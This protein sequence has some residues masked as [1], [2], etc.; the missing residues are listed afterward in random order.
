MGDIG[1]LIV[2]ATQAGC[3]Y[4]LVALAYLL[5]IRPTGVINFSLGEWCMLAAFGAVAVTTQLLVP[6]FAVP[7]ALGFVIVLV[8][9]GVFGALVEVLTVRPLIE[10]GAPVMSPILALLGV[11]V[12]AREAGTIAGGPDPLPLDPPFGF[13]RIEVGPFAGLPQEFFIIATTA[14]VFV[15]AWL[16]FERTVWGKRFEAVAI[17]RRAAALMGINLRLVGLLAFVGAGLVT[18]VVGVLVAGSSG[19]FYLMGLPL[20][21]QGF[22]ALVIGGIG[23]VEG[24]LLGGLILGVTEAFAARYLPIPSGLIQ[25]VPLVLLIVFLLVRPTGLLKAKEARL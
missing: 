16:F 15:A 10:R 2:S 13:M 21:I 11:F 22:T 7:F 20:A 5:I 14:V 3:L 19:A 24:A 4:G 23:R 8:L 1:E 9:L 25:G 12:I 6:A 17:N 18:A